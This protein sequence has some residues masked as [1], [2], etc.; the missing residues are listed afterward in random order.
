M[1]GTET[2]LNVQRKAQAQAA[3]AAQEAQR[4]TA[5]AETPPTTQNAAQTASEEL[6]R[7]SETNAQE[8]TGAAKKIAA[9]GGAESTSV[10][11]DPAQHA[12]VEQAVI[13]EYQAAVD[14]NLVNYIETVRDNKGAKIG[15]FTLKAVGDRAAQDIKRLTGVDVSG[16][17]TAIES[18]I[19]EHILNRHGKS[20]TADHSMRDINDIARIQYVL[21]NYDNAS[22]G[23]KSNAY[24]T[25]KEN[26]R[27]GQADTVIFSKAVNGTYYVVEAVPNAKA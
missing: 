22:Y 14:D 16:N 12:K 2:P 6:N 27:P 15:R 19:I 5:G 26:G 1:T 20:G 24:Q 17:K 8:Q 23:G 4:T 11:T 3:E 7:Q 10:N 13:D 9:Q 18:R 25:V 21:D